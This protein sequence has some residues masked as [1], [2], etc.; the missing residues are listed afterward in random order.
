MRG[1][2]EFTGGHP[3]QRI[4]VTDDGPGIP[5]ADL[6]RIFVP[7]YTTKS[8]GTGLGLAIVQKIVVQHGGSV[9]ARNSAK[10]GAEFIISLPLSR[11]AAATV[12]S[13]ATTI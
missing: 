6:S 3:V 7:F 1:A 9:E 12:D 2:V 5:A 11:E 10:G 8:N 13:V 4:S